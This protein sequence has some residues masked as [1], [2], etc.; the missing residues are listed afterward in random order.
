MLRAGIL[1][2]VHLCCLKGATGEGSRIAG[3]CDTSG[4]PSVVTGSAAC[5]VKVSLYYPG[6]NVNVS[7]HYAASSGTIRI[8][9]AVSAQ[10][11]SDQ[12]VQ[13]LLPSQ[14]D[15]FVFDYGGKSEIVPVVTKGG[16]EATLALHGTGMPT[17]SVQTKM[18]GN[19]SLGQL[20]TVTFG[21]MGTPSLADAE[22]GYEF[23]L[24]NVRNP[25]A[26]AGL[27]I[28]DVEINLMRANGSVWYYGSAPLPEIVPGN[29]TATE[30]Q[31]EL[32]TPE[33]GIQ[34][35]IR[36][37]MTT[38][39]WIPTDGRIQIF[40]P[41]GFILTSGSTVAI[42]QT[43][44]GEE[45]ALYVSSMNVAE[46]IVTMVMAGSLGFEI[47]PLAPLLM[48]SFQLTKIRNPY[49]GVTG[50]FGLRTFSGSG[51]IIDSG[52]VPHSEFSM[53]LKHILALF[54]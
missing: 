31:F 34:S 35:D 50:V 17:F 10:V 45:N 28:A 11:S 20:V 14:R 4:S 43:N 53:C 51:H 52:D 44:L 37:T 48:G 41:E 33:A 38:R 3:N 36:V 9:F 39:G 54:F 7:R 27:P 22:A 12:E 26:N 21:S 30:V 29:L 25:Y 1:A 15:G 24:T 46:R 5:G 8:G 32:V 23:D 49:S 16:T 18:N 6:Q 40:L 42:G 2:V 19:V 13:V 47:S